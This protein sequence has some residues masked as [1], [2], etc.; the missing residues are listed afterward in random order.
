MLSL[1]D[2][3][4]QLITGH[5]TKQERALHSIH[6]ILSFRR[7]CSAFRHSPSPFVDA[8]RREADA[9]LAAADVFE[10]GKRLD[11]RQATYLEHDESMR[12]AACCLETH[13]H[14]Y[15]EYCAYCLNDVATISLAEAVRIN[16]TLTSLNCSF[17][18]ITDRGAIAL[19]ACLS[20]NGVLKYLD[21]SHN[22][23]TDVGAVSIGEALSKNGHLEFLAIN[24]SSQGDGITDRGAAAIANAMNGKLN[25]VSLIQNDITS[26]G[27]LSFVQAID[28]VDQK[29][30]V[31]LNYCPISNRKVNDA[32]NASLVEFSY[33]SDYTDDELV[34]FYYDSDY[35]D[36]GD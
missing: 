7:V 30:V 33:D 9:L 32:V 12:D 14:L 11:P 27:L 31:E 18:D 4:I 8:K 5:L 21:L 17:N 25:H 19:A 23:L 16:T 13:L 2:D 35:T 15:G 22:L 1:D 34:E 10:E 3:C 36:D 24:Y 29:K 6:N 20:E 28:K 26:K